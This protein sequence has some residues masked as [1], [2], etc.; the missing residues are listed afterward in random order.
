MH[1]YN[2]DGLHIYIQ[3]VG[4]HIWISSYVSF[5]EIICMQPIIYLIF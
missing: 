3:E 2:T 5:K 1:M 4:T